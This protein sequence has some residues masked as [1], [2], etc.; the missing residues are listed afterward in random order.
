MA[1]SNSQRS[2]VIEVF[3]LDGG[4]TNIKFAVKG[5]TQVGKMPSCIREIDTSIYDLE[6]PIDDPN[7]AIVEYEGVSYLVGALAYQQ[8]GLPIFQLGSSYGAGK[9][10][11][12]KIMFMAALRDID[13][14][15]S[16]PVIEQLNILVPDAR[17]NHLQETWNYVGEE[18][19]DITEFHV[20]GKLIRPQVREVKFISEGIPSFQFVKSHGLFDAYAAIPGIS[21]FGI[22]DIGG[23]ESTFKLID[24]NTGQ[25]NWES[26][27]TMPG[28]NAL[29]ESISTVLKSQSG[30]RLSPE[31]P[32]ILSCLSIQRYIYQAPG[33]SAFDFESVYLAVRNR[34]AI[35]ILQ[36]IAPKFGGTVGSIAVVGG[37]AH[38]AEDLCRKVEDG[39]LF[40][41]TED[42][43]GVDPQ[44]INAISLTY[45]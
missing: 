3:A 11:Y 43:T 30:I 19:T 9:A 27:V 39:R 2:G 1:K 29:A 28:L 31:L 42:V 25:I 7:S 8:G 37:G 5:S 26:E 23:G 15:S 34:W 18:I 38:H 4:N 36:T 14:L 22:L 20:N 17:R 12:M 21:D 10:E 32:H 6:Y 13:Q 35:R 33:V 45:L 16:C 44:K 41:P 24:I 40:V